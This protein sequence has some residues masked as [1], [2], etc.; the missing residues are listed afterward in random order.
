MA[1]PN[2]SP[3]SRF[4]PGQSGNPGGKPVAARNALQKKFLY[5]LAKDF[6]EHGKQAIV[7]M[8]ENDPSS[9]IRAIVALMPKE[10]EISRPL[11]ELTDEQLD[12]AIIAARAILTAQSS[13]S[14]ENMGSGEKPK[15]AKKQ[16]KV[17]STVPETG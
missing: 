7:D 11:D 2:P 1:N 4:K 5:E 17:V 6:D 14:P 3:E 16:A 8:R 15:S 10:L 12:A 13:G 9:Y